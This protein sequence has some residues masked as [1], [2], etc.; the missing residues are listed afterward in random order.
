MVAD[1]DSIKF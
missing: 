1:T